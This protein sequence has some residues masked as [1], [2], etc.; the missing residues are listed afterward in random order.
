FRMLLAY[1]EMTGKAAVLQAVEKAMALTMQRYSD[2]GRN[3][4][5]LENAFG[6]VTHG[7]MMT[8]VCE[9]LHRITGK[10]EYQEYATYLYRAFSTY[11]V[12]RAFNDMRYPF[13]AKKDS[14]FTGHGVHTYEHLRTLINAYYNTGYPELKAAWE[15]ALYKLDQ[16][17]LPSGAG[18]GNEWIAGLKAD[19]T[20]TST[21]FCCM[22]ELRNFYGSAFQKTGNVHF[23]DQAEKLTFNAIMGARNVNGSAITYGKSD[24]CYRLDGHH[25]GEGESHADVRYK[26]SPTHSD[27]AVCCVPN[28]SRNFSYYL[29]QMWLKKE[30]G[31][32]AALYGPSILETN[33][34]GKR[35]KIEQ[36]TQYPHSEAIRFT[37]TLEEPVEMAIYL[38]R[39]QWSDRLEVEAEGASLAVELDYY[40]LYKRWE[41]GDEIAL[42]FTPVVERKMLSA[43]EFY[44]QRG[45]LVYAYPIP[46]REETIKTYA[47]TNFRDYY[48]L[49][50]ETEYEAIRFAKQ[51]KIDYRRTAN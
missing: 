28:Y 6:G 24:N 31:L 13:L 20:I 4:F 37:L 23:A 12:N 25:H 34:Q 50:T 46:H 40:R 39:P 29:D 44:F 27:P 9:S 18:H 17:I 32:V 21:E 7:L 33:W 42:Y 49:P 36:R 30:D 43:D 1:Y 5:L 8:D 2:T 41:E 3:P 10:Q 48:C 51:A 45:P 38:R 26:Y 35:I 47:G 16:C 19:P 15:N 14:L 11:S 22:L